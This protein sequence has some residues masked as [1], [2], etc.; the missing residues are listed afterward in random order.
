MAVSVSTLQSYYEDVATHGV[1]SYPRG[2]ET[3]GLVDQ[4]FAFTPGHVFVRPNSN[5]NIGFVEGLQFIDGTFSIKP[6]KIVAPNARLDLFTGQSAYGPRVAT[7]LPRVIEELRKDRNSRRAVMMIAHPT[8]TA[9]T[10]PCTLS[11]QFQISTEK[12][13]PQLTT[14]VTMRSSDLVWGM[15]TDIIQFG[16]ICMVV[17]NCVSAIPELCVVNSGNV[18]I[19][20]ETKLKS[21]ESYKFGGT[22]KLPEFYDLEE[23]RNWARWAL[24]GIENGALPKEIFKY[25]KA[26]SVRAEQF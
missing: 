24:K 1:K 11:M 23:Y 3:V 25:E 7:Q 14:I 2:L 9:E 20:E 5:L 16:I 8:D 10:L 19:Y 26:R 17:G 18:H 15:P 12:G 22:Y 13:I 21:Y 4:S 6:F